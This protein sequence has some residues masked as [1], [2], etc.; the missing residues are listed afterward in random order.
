MTDHGSE[1]KIPLP[2]G[3]GGMQRNMCRKCGIQ[4]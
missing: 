1:E 4:M 3:G 2:R